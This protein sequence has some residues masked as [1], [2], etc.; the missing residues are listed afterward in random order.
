[1]RRP[2]ILLAD[3]HLLLLEAFQ[4]ILEP[5]FDVVGTV[6]DGRE[7][8]KVAP[9]LKPEVIV[10]DVSMP[11]L[12]GLDAGAKLRKSMPDTK[13]VFL[14]MHED[15]D[16]VSKALE[17]GASGF[18]LKSS[19]AS[20]LSKAI[21]KVL[22]GKT[23]VTPLMT[24]SENFSSAQAFDGKR[25]DKLTVRQREVLQLLAE[26]NTMKKIAEILF[27]TPRTVAFHKY[28][29][30]EIL[31]ISNSAELVQFAIKNGLVVQ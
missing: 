6:S 3:D 19:A 5:E 4:R 20:E 26:G 7:L 12:N 31:E 24:G 16:L 30:M 15:P 29:I 22:A 18:L 9:R 14:T 27:V 11:Q 28:R 23:Y 13:L 25:I 17:I 2:R 10:L 1:M 8:L 21:W